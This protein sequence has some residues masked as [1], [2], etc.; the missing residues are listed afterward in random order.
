MVNKN[1]NYA[2]FPF[3]SKAVKRHYVQ[4]EAI[5]ASFTVCF[6]IRMDMPPQE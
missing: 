5:V 1:I 2:E 3:T 4:S 6:I